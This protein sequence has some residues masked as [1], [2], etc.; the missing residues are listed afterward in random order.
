M[1]RNPRKVRWTKAHRKL[2]GK[3]LVDDKT[4]E[5]E[6]KRNRPE[7]YDRQ[8]VQ[9]TIKAIEKVS[10]VRQKRNIRLHELRM[11]RAKAQAKGAQK[12][13][14]DKEIHLIKAPIAQAAEKVKVAAEKRQGDA[15][16]E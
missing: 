13:Q 2:A 3:E 12:A 9:K 7:K 11:Q 1:K 8:L 4:F 16:M 5:F 14:L 15:M 6:R 10:E